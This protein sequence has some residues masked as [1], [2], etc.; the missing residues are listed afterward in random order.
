MNAV[1]KFHDFLSE[2]EF[3]EYAELIK[4][5]TGI[6]FR[7][8]K[9]N[10]IEYRLGKRLFD[11]GLSAKQYLELVRTSE[12]EMKFFINQLT[13]HKTEWFRESEHFDFLKNEFAGH[14]GPLY[15]WSAACSTGEEP[16]TIMMT[17]G[18]AGV[19]YEQQRILATDISAVCVNQARQ[20]MYPLPAIEAGVPKN[21]IN[22]YFIRASGLSKHNSAFAM[23]NPLWAEST[24]KFKELNLTAFELPKGMQFDVIFIRNVLIYFDAVETI[25]ILKCLTKYLRHKGYLILGLTEPLQH[26]QNLGLKRVSKSIYQYE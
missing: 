16:Y 25:K 22:K 15:V 23:V 11:K 12:D 6:Q 21:L 18:E 26:P 1:Q 5:L 24:I 3:H 14:R 9:K 10:L 17:L 19:S 2:R 8:E 7:M 13:T 20:G 4:K